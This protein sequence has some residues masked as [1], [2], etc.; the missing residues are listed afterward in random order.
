MEGGQ[1]GGRRGEDG[2]KEGKQ[3][4][5][6]DQK[7]STVGAGIIDLC[8]PGQRREREREGEK[9]ETQTQIKIGEPTSIV[10]CKNK[11][12]FFVCLFVYLFLHGWTLWPLRCSRTCQHVA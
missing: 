12:F 1:C 2:D 4:K 3:R 10:E 6:K 9:R 11:L 7:A 5:K 8:S